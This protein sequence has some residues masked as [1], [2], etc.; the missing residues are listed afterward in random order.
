MIYVYL[1]PVGM[2]P[3]VSVSAVLMLLTIWLIVRNMQDH[4]QKPV[5]GLEID[6]KAYRKTHIYVGNGRWYPKHLFDT[7]WKEYK[8]IT[9]DIPEQPWIT[10]IPVCLYEHKTIRR[11]NPQLLYGKRI[12]KGFSYQTISNLSQ[13]PKTSIRYIESGKMLLTD[14]DKIQKLK[15]VLA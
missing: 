2:V 5:E 12:E 6:P 3:V 14:P 8:A 13:I 4:Y 7:D 11:L 9:N 15:E 1:W 10:E